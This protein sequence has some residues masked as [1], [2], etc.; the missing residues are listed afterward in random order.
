VSEVEGSEAGED[1]LDG[2][3]GRQQFRLYSHGDTID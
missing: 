2:A 3:V 1:L